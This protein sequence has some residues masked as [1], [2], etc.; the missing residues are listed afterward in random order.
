[1]AKQATRWHIQ[2]MEFQ[3]RH[4]RVRGWLALVLALSAVLAIGV[5][6]AIVA[7]GIFVILLPLLVAVTALS[8]LFPRVRWR[9]RKKVGEP[10]IIEGEYRVLDVHARKRKPLN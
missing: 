10:E 1:M 5:A 7:L 3:V 9:Q 4:F 8:Y 6:L 2:G